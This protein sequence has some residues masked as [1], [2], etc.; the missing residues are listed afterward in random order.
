MRSCFLDH[1]LISSGSGHNSSFVLS[2]CPEQMDLEN[3]VS[4]LTNKIRS[5]RVE[6]KKQSKKN[7][8]QRPSSAASGLV[9]Y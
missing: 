1:N 5:I 3:P 7:K 2:G 4:F 9:T 8:S 6:L